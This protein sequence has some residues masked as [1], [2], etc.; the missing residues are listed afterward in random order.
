M[1]QTA[2]HQKKLNFTAHLF[3]SA[4]GT[5]ESKDDAMEDEYDSTTLQL[6]TDGTFVFTHKFGQ[7]EGVDREF[8]ATFYGKFQETGSELTLQCSTIDV[9]S[10]LAQW[11]KNYVRSVSARLHAYGC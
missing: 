8:C 1:A 10:S 7:S 5:F 6:N 11:D 4:A 9:K 2:S 3:E